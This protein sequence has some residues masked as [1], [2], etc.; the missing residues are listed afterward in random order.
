MRLLLSY[1]KRQKKLLLMLCL[2]G[3]VFACVFYLYNLPVEAVGYASVLCLAIGLLLFT[4]SYLCYLTRH[5]LLHLLIQN[6][7]ETTFRLPAP[8][9][10]L[11]KDYQD[12]LM[13]V[14]QDRNRITAE[15]DS[16]YHD[17]TDYYTLWAHQIKTPIAAMHLL[18]Q[19]ELDRDALFT[20]LLK[21]EEYVEMALSY[22]RLGSDSTDYV[23]RRCDLDALVRSCVR[24]Y[25]KLFILKQITLSF[26]ESNLIVLTDE[27]WLAFAIGQILSN[28]LKYTPE[29]GVI[30]IYHDQ[31]SLMIADNGIGIR[32]ED[33][34]R[35]FEKGFTGYNGREKQKSTG[36]GLYLCHRILTQLGHGITI[37]SEPGKG[38]LVRLNLSSAPQVIE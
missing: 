37:V 25:A 29:H 17:M 18:L 13:A 36:I 34:P 24:R 1:L 28:A 11:E 20:E 9:S 22:L 7:E 30:H 15:H 8:M 35:V 12:L 4:I 6:V 26:E 16:A 38:T 23:L 5:Q 27:K 14:C 19:E 32:Q 21:I 3:A 31:E 2:F 33:L 10:S